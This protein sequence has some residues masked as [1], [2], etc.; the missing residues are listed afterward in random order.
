M[1]LYVIKKIFKLIK[2]NRKK[3]PPRYNIYNV[4]L[5][6]YYYVRST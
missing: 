3:M 5:L 4:K 1:V 2:E 6:I